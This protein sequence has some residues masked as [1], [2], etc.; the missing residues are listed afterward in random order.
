MRIQTLATM[1]AALTLTAGAGDRVTAGKRTLT[2]EGAR[3]VIDAAV[4]LATK[5][6]TSLTP[7]EKRS[8]V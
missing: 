6:M 5:S 8:R 2:L 1:A 4:D 7:R 3:K